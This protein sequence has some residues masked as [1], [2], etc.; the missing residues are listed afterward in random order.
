MMIITTVFSR[1]LLSGGFMT[2]RAVSRMPTVFNPSLVVKEDVE[3]ITFF[4]LTQH[5]LMIPEI[6]KKQNC[7]QF[8]CAHFEPKHESLSLIL[9]EL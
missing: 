6:C 3:I 4:I 7:T 2:T 9:T 8:Q 1:M 5:R